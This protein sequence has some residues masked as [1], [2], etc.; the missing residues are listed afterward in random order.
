SQIMSPEPNLSWA[1]KA[2]SGGAGI[3]ND[4]LIDN[5]W[6]PARTAKFGNP[7]RQSFRRCAGELLDRSFLVVQI[8]R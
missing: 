2:L 1:P 6:M 3:F 8:M 5:F 4:P 7:R